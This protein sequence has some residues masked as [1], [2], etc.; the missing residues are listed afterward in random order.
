LYASLSSSHVASRFNL[1]PVKGQITPGADADLALIDVR[2]TF[3]V[4]SR[5]LLSRHQISPYVGRRLTGKVVQTILRGKTVFKNG[6]IVSKP[7]GCLVRP[8]H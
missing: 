2:Q 3:E 5:D 4:K 1:P 6:K 8:C 7:M